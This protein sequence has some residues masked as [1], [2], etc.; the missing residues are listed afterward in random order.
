MKNFFLLLTVLP[1]LLGAGVSLAADV[2][3]QTGFEFAWWKDSEENTGYQAIIPLRIS[4]QIREF[5]WSVLGGYASTGFDPHTADTTALSHTLDTKVNFSYAFLDKLPFDVL[6]G[7][8]FNLPTGKT[9]LNPQD[10]SLI[11]D[12]DLVPISQLGQGFNVNPT[13]SVAKEWGRWV[14]GLGV[15]YVWRGTYDYATNITDY[16]P[17][18]ILT[19]TAEARYEFSSL[20]SG[21]VFGQY[22]RFG[23]D[24]VNGRSIY[25]EGD[26]YLSGVGLRYSPKSWDAAFTLR[27]IY[28]AK[29]ELPTLSGD[30]SVPSDN[31]HGNEGGGDLLLRYFWSQPTTLWVRITGLLIQANDF[32]TSSSFF[33]GQ[34]QKASLELGWKRAFGERWEARLFV[35]GFTMHDEERALPDVRGERTYNGFSAGGTMI[36]RF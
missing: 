8:D 29:S 3:V 13:L 30:L 18:D 36:A 27:Y 25:R 4:S 14:A 21:R 11:M 22:A 7:L 34:R 12:P 32:P 26:F 1:I 28:R 31:I 16:D 24:E 10:L 23:K 33:V 17:G 35:R 5:S 9:K 19:A 15:G 2:D 20:W 6:L